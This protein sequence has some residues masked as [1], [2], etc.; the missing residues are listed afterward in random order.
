MSWCLTSKIILSP[1]FHHLRM[2]EHVYWIKYHLY[3]SFLCFLLSANARTYRGRGTP[4]QKIKNFSGL[5]V[6]FNPPF[7]PGQ[8]PIPAFFWPLFSRLT[9]HPCL[10]AS[11]HLRT[12][13]LLNLTSWTLTISGLGILSGVCSSSNSNF[14]RLLGHLRT[15]LSDSNFLRQATLLLDFVVFGLTLIWR[16]W[17]LRPY[18]QLFKEKEN[19]LSRDSTPG[20]WF[21][22][23]ELYRLSYQALVTGNGVLTNLYLLKSG[24]NKK[25]RPHSQCPH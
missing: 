17:Q 22:S 2:S 20:L 16:T 5:S 7:F 13:L 14:L 3:Y 11:T 15:L 4:A 21:R 18:S 25:K 24:Q 9:A 23:R 19:W 10:L 12:S 1:T 6:F 8:P